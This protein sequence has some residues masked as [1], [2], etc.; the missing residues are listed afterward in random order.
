MALN[1]LDRFVVAH[2]DSSKQQVQLMTT[3]ALHVATKLNQTNGGL[4]TRDLADLS[5]GLFDKEEIE[6]AEYHLLGCLQWQVHPPTA[7]TFLYL[8]LELASNTLPS[9]LLDQVLYLLDHTQLDSFFVPY[10][11]AVVAVA[12]LG[13]VTKVDRILALVDPQQVRLPR[14]HIFHCRCH[15]QRFVVETPRHVPSPVSAMQ[16]PC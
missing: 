15:M 7:E 5:R 11:A 3:T 8:F 4:S 2:P 16:E 9:R 12:A 1:Y 6:Q 10:S 14:D 13:Y